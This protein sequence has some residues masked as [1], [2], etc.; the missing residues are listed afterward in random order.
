MDSSNFHN[1][2]NPPVIRKAFALAETLTILMI[3]G[4]ISTLTLPTV[5]PRALGHA[6]KRAWKVNYALISNAYDIAL[7]EAIA[8]GI[9]VAFNYGVGDDDYVV[10]IPE[11]IGLMQKHLKVTDSCNGHSRSPGGKWCNGCKWAQTG[12]KADYKTLAGGNLGS[13]DF[14][15]KA[16]LLKNGAAVY[17]GGS[18]SGNTIL[19]DVN[20]YTKGPN[21]LGKDVFA[22]HVNR[23][24][25]MM[26]VGAGEMDMALKEGAQGCAPDIGQASAAYLGQAAGA[27]CS[28]KYL[29]E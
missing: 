19:V 1:P 10:Q 2:N 16:L 8:S 21:T 9:D 29:Y 26:P 23:N 17:F 7:P 5:L 6:Y 20:N 3:I 18:L 22:I 28:A 4:I 11:F 14:G 24:N 12:G 25:E 15:R 27:G 13:Y